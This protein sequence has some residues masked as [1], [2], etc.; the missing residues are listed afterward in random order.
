VTDPKWT[1][2][3]FPIVMTIFLFLVVNV[4]VMVTISL[5]FGLLGLHHYFPHGASVD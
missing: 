3:I 2:R 4:L 1:R 5:V